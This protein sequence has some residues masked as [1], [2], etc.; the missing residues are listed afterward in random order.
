MLTVSDPI[1]M[2]AIRDRW[3][4][5]PETVGLVPTMGD[6]HEGHLSLMRASRE[7]CDRTVATVFV[8][9][10]QF[11]EGED[12]DRYPRNRERDENLA[13]EVGVDLLFI[14][15]AAAIYPD[16]FSTEVEVTGMSEVLCGDPRSRGPGHFKGVTTVVAKL[17]NLVDPDAA[18]FGQKDAQQAALIRQMVRD[19]G[20]RTEVVVLPTV[21]EED[22]LAMSSRNRY[23]TPEGRTRALSL[24]RALEAAR[25]AYPVTDLDRALMRGR[26]VLASEGI[27]PEYLEARLSGNLEPAGPDP[28]EP[29]FIAVAAEIDGTRLIDN[30]EIDPGGN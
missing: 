21:R 10:T 27:E 14:P 15:E 4:L 13:Q 6:L 9:P 30:V 22:G 24:N 25:A 23:L 20:F 16:G 5:D 26:E 29:F 11:G 19:L 18:F 7:R 8:N 12:F 17:L 28:G 2:A 1:E 3:R